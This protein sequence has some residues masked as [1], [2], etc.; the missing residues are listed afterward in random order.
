[1]ILNDLIC[2]LKLTLKFSMSRTRKNEILV[3]KI[4]EPDKETGESD[5][6]KIDE[7]NKTELKLGNNGNIR[8][9]TPWTDKYKWDIKRKN[10]KTRGTPIAFR[11]IG[12]SDDKLKVHPIRN[13]IRKYLLEKFSN[14]LHCGNHKDLCID[15]KN[16]MYNDQKVLNTTTQQE[17]D[18]QV[19]CNKCNKDLKHQAN[20]K[21]K[22]TG[23]LYSVKNLHL[24]NFKND[25]FD[26]PWE[27]GLTEYNE[28]Y[29][30]CKMYT[31][32]YDIEDF[33][34]KRDIFITITI[35]LNKII[36]KKIKL[37]N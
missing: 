16:D 29:K 25:N 17:K 21:E 32:W 10:N 24:S 23:K 36:K 22:K 11:T 14:C 27:K 13:N 3:A 33:C 20:E 9:N 26:Y 28:Q 15:H 6:K 7:I 35:P 5:W 12:F 31:Y 30:S 2:S 34:R 4:F 19:L 8:Q 37:I 18:F 1:M